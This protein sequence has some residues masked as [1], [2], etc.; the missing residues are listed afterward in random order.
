VSAGHGKNGKYFTLQFVCEVSK[1]EQIQ[2]RRT[3]IK[4]NYQFAEEVYDLY[5]K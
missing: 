4:G 3:L 5:I 1:N 2:P